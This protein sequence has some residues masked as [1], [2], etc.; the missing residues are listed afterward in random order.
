MS[1]R[2]L[3]EKGCTY[4]DRRLPGV[5]LEPPKL[6]SCV[7]G[8]MSARIRPPPRNH[9]LMTSSIHC[10]LSPR[11]SFI[12]SIIKMYLPDL[13]YYKIKDAEWSHGKFAGRFTASTSPPPRAFHSTLHT[14][15]A[16]T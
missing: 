4:L 14:Q 9:T 6:L 1:R 11:Q 10:L 15:D 12:I 16:G 13:K 5:S 8:T 2:D 7:E 3:E